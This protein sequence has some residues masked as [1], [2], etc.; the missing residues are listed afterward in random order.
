[1]LLS[2]PPP[3]ATEATTVTTKQIPTTRRRE[4]ARHTLSS[5]QAHHNINR[6][7]PTIHLQKANIAPYA[8][9][10]CIY[11][12]LVI[13]VRPHVMQDAHDEGSKV[14]EVT[15]EQ[16][17]LSKNCNLIMWPLWLFVLFFG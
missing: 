11:Q 7:K 14:L 3:Q 13:E 10:I 6:Y 1:M 5:Q 9:V 4:F 17:R 16:G 12:H 8:K 2:L 15:V